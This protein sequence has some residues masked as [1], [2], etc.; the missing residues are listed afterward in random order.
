MITTLLVMLGGLLYRQRGGGIDIPLGTQGARAVW[1]VPTGV[2]AWAQTG[3]V[4]VGAIV[5]VTQFAGLMIPHGTFQDNGTCG[6]TVFS[7]A[8]GMSMVVL[9]RSLLTVIA[10]DLAGGGAWVAMVAVSFLAGPAY[11]L[12]WR[13]PSTIPH[14]ERGCALAEFFIGCLL[15][16]GILWAT[17]V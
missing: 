12:A 5:A 14:L 11:A 16:G 9:V 3:S 4:E 6:G 15:W 1:C 17:G 8:V 7:D 13:I 2:L 10:V